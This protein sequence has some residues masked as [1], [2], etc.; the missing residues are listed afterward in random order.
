VVRLTE[1]QAQKLA[2]IREKHGVATDEEAIRELIDAIAE[3]LQN[4][5][6]W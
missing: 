1:L 2:D 3:I 4:D 5:P 6:E